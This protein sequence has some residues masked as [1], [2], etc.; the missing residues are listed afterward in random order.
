MSDPADI[1]DR[2]TQALVN[3]GLQSHAMRAAL[4]ACAP[5]NTA[6][7]CHECDDA[8]NPDRLEINPRARL[9]VPCKRDAEVRAGRFA[10]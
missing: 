8:I 5:I 3:G 1:A 4:E 10:R 2:D 7:R 9:C 6:G